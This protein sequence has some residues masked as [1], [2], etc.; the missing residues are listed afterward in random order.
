L[1]RDIG[2]EP[3]TVDE[4]LRLVEMARRSRQVTGWWQGF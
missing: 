4:R 1:R 2:I 3:S